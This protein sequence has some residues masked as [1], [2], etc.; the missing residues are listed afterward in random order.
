MQVALA[1]GGRL[2]EADI[3]KYHRD[4]FVVVE[5][6]LTAEQLEGARHVL[7]ELEAGAYGVSAPDDIYDLEPGHT[8]DAP[9]LRRIKF[10]HRN[11]A[12]FG[13]LGR[14][15]EIKSVLRQLLG[16]AFRIFGSKINFKSAQY[17]SPVGWHQDW[18]FYPHTN[19]TFTIA[20]IM[21]DDCTME[22]GPL[23]F[24]PG[25]HRGEIYDHH[26]DGVFCGAM[27][28]HA[29]GADFAKAQPALGKA[30]SVSF[31]HVRIVHGSA[32]NTSNQPRGLLL[33]EYAAADA[34]PLD[35]MRDW[36]KYE[37]S[38]IEGH[39]TTTPRMEALPVRLPL[40]QEASHI[41]TIY[42]VQSTV[43]S[44]YFDNMNPKNPE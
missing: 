19:D 7:R 8:P 15:E 18:A 4:G 3:A 38:F 26:A 34:W 20:S 32:A 6:L 44:H 5:G 28:P 9:R 2:S 29:A 42:E 17:G 22:N 41:R 33:Y 43:K 10:P 13:E 21:L 27:D 1:A 37:E 36:Q 30:G 39:A 24:I 12:F 16:P 14:S 25:S 40:P 23:L 11:N 31:H 35:G